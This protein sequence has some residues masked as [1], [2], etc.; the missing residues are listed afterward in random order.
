MPHWGIDRYATPQYEHRPLQ[1]CAI[2]IKSEYPKENGY[3][4]FLYKL[5]FFQ[6]QV[7]QRRAEILVRGADD[8]VGE[9]HLFHAVGTPAGYTGNGEQRGEQIL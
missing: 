3:S 2:T 4:L 8:A 6:R 7:I 9:L 5:P 1:T